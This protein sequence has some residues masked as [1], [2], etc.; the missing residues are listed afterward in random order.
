MTF[1]LSLIAEQLFRD[2]G[3]YLKVIR[4]KLSKIELVMEFKIC[5]NEEFAFA[6]SVLWL[7]VIR[8]SIKSFES[9]SNLLLLRRGS[10]L[11]IGFR[12]AIHSNTFTCGE[13][14][15]A[16]PFLVDQDFILLVLKINQSCFQP[17]VLTI[18]L[19]DRSSHQSVL[20]PFDAPMSHIGHTDA[21]VTPVEWCPFKSDSRPHFR[22]SRFKWR[23]RAAPLTPSRTSTAAPCHSQLTPSDAPPT[24]IQYHSEWFYLDVHPYQPVVAH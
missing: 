18:I 10:K 21:P 13:V 7:A 12:I 3:T 5:P 8:K 19:C 22:P 6:P 14:N 23:P 2:N 24:E 17:G 15:R 20:P 1:F 4:G 9:A 16:I 11:K